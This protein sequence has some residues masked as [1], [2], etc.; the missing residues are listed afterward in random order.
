MQEGKELC[1]KLSNGY[2]FLSLA[3]DVFIFSSLSAQLPT[4]RDSQAGLRLQAGKSWKIGIFFFKTRKW[5]C[6]SYFFE[7]KSCQSCEATELMLY[8]ILRVQEILC[9]S[10]P[11]CQGEWLSVGAIFTPDFCAS[12]KCPPIQFKAFRTHLTIIFVRNL[13]NPECA[14]LTTGLLLSTCESGTGVVPDRGLRHLSL[15]TWMASIYNILQAAKYSL[16][17]KLTLRPGLLPLHVFDLN[18]S[19]WMGYTQLF[20]CCGCCDFTVAICK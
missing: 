17:F 3:S 15:Y 7:V 18:M 14:R 10:K 11:V 16:F 13:C 1:L 19:Q 6:F 20:P 5:V 12:V 4:F 2:S 9:F 8:F